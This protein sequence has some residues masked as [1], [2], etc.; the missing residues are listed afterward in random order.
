M[1]KLD[2]LY[3]VA[4]VLAIAASGLVTYD[5]LAVKSLSQIVSSNLTMMGSPGQQSPV[6]V[7][8]GSIKPFAAVGWTPADSMTIISAKPVDATTLAIDADPEPSHPGEE[9]EA[10]LGVSSAWQITLHLHDGAN[11]IKICPVASTTSTACIAATS[12]VYLMVQITGMNASFLNDTSDATGSDSYFSY[13]D[14]AH[15]P[16]GT[17]FYEHIKKIDISGV[18]GGGTY[19]Y[20]CTHGRCNIFIG[21]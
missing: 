21:K 15:L 8:G 2:V 11:T 5:T 20:R 12:S 14:A 16:D 4:S 13:H 10:W 9:P 19:N 7:V 3:S 6:R 1:R 18:D 17:S